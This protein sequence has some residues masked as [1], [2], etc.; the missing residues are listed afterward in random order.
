MNMIDVQN[1]K[2]IVKCPGSIEALFTDWMGELDSEF[3]VFEGS[4]LKVITIP[5]L[6]QWLAHLKIDNLDYIP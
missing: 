6:K 4:I 3:K 2:V 1:H 5:V